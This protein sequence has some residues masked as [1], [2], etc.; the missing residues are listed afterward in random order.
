MSLH[1]PTSMPSEDVDV[2][3]EDQLQL[4]EFGTI[5]SRLFEIRDDMKELKVL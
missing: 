2:R 5:N 1:R 3:E 4:N